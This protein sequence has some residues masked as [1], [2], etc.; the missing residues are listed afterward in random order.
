MHLYLTRLLTAYRDGFRGDF[1]GALWPEESSKI[2]FS[3]IQVMG[4]PY[5]RASVSKQIYNVS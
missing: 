2:G 1:R 5:A 4:Q 3:F